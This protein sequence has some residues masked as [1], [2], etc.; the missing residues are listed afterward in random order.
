MRKELRPWG[1]HVIAIEPGSMKTEIW[2]KGV[3]AAPELREKLG[4]RARELYGPQ[5]DKLQEMAVDAGR[6]GAPPDLVAQAVE[7]ALTARRPRTRYLVGRDAKAQVA[8]DT[9]LPDRA[10]D[11]LGARFF[12]AD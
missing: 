12:A 2:D 1:I 4:P 8:I 7:R 6:R 9:V 10:V 3:K 5:L 11:A